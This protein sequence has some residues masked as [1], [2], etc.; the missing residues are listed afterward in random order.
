VKATG[1]LMEKG[2]SVPHS[3]WSASEILSA[4]FSRSRIVSNR[5]PRIGTT[6]TCAVN[7]TW[8]SRVTVTAPPEES[9]SCCGI[10]HPHIYRAVN[11]VGAHRPRV[12]C[13]TA[14][15]SKAS[16]GQVSLRSPYRSSALLARVFWI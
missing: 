1:S 3:S 16:D 10:V 15:A 5:F 14:Y 4:S 8:W 7:G 12:D 13:Q 2:T 6:L 11:G 9:D